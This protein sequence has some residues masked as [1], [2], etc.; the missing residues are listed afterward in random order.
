MILF[1]T[2]LSKLEIKHRRELETSSSRADLPVGRLSNN[3][4]FNL[5]RSTQIEILFSL[6]NYAE[7]QLDIDLINIFAGDDPHFLHSGVDEELVNG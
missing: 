1:E 5:K 4:N 6:Q 7:Q 2:S 3:N